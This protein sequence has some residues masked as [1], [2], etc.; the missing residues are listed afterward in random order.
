LKAP[1]VIRQ[2]G[3]GTQVIV[4]VIAAGVSS[5]LAISVLLRYVSKHSY[6]VF[7]LYRVVLGLAVLAIIYWR[8]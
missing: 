4:G 3:L 7:A 8:G 6:G 2:G 1:D 5:W